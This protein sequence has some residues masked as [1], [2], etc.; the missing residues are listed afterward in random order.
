MSGAAG[1]KGVQQGIE[2]YKQAG[3]MM[4]MQHE[5][6]FNEVMNRG[7]FQERVDG[8]I[9]MLNG[10]PT[11]PGTAQLTQGPN[12]EVQLVH[13][14]PGKEKPHV[15]TLK[16]NSP[17]EILMD[18][19]LR[20][21]QRTN[22]DLYFK[23]KEMEM[24]QQEMLFNQGMS[25]LKHDNDTERL[26]IDREELELRRLQ[27]DR[28][29]GLRQRALQEESKARGARDAQER[30][31]PYGLDAEGNPVFYDERGQQF[32]T[33]KNPAGVTPFSKVSGER[34]DTD[35]DKQYR[36][37][38]REG[39]MDDPPHRRIQVAEMMGVDPR[40]FGLSMVD[41]T[42]AAASAK[43]LGLGNKGKAPPPAKLAPGLREQLLRDS[44]LS[45]ARRGPVQ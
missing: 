15:T 38:L 7:S 29:Y 30:W 23:R 32:R 8:L 12:G 14:V 19:A 3:E 40:R 27:G 6:E 36:Q 31:K 9:G 1:A 5:Q 25:Y 26:E 45:G 41:P 11:T 13:S 16:G 35:A 24:K 37:Y 21:R 39:G 2:L 28:E 17:D 18:L 10:S 33:I 34:A 22:T 43:Q 4:K 44:G 42:A 20:V